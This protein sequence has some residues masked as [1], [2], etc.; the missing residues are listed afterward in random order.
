M[1]KFDFI[2]D[3]FIVNNTYGIVTSTNTISDK[4]IPDE[5]G[6]F[7]QRIFGPIND[8]QCKCG[9][10]KSV[11]YRGEICPKC[12]VEVNTSRVR[13]KRGGR[14][15]LLLP[16]VNTV[17]KGL[18]ASIFDLPVKNFSEYLSENPAVH[19]LE[20]D[21]V[22]KLKIDGKYYYTVFDTD[23][24]NTYDYGTKAM[25][26]ILKYIDIEHLKS[27]YKDLNT[28]EIL[29]YF[30]KS[31]ISLDNLIHY[32]IYVIPPTYR[33]FYYL[34]GSY[35]VKSGINNY[36]ISLIGRNRR[37]INMDNIIEDER[38]KNI[39]IWREFVFIQNIVDGLILGNYKMNGIPVKGIKELMSGKTG[40]IR[41]NMLGKRVRFTGRSVIVA[42]P[43]CKT[44][45]NEG[46]VPYN[47][48]YD[49]YKP[50]ILNRLGNYG[51][52]K[53]E[54]KIKEYRND[55]NL[56]SKIIYEEIDNK[57]YFVLNRQPT[58]H[59]GSIQ[60]LKVRVNKDKS[61]QAILLDP[62]ITEPLNADFDG[63]T[64]QMIFPMTV[65]AVNDVKEKLLVVKNINNFRNNTVQL[66][67]SQEA[68][69][70]LWYLTS[71]PTNKSGYLTSLED[72]DKTVGFNILFNML[73]QFEAE[74]LLENNTLDKKGVY[75][76]MNNILSS[77]YYNDSYLDR[78][79]TVRE[80]ALLGF[81]TISE[82]GF[83]I[84]FSE[85]EPE[86]VE[87]EN[88]TQ[89][90]KNVELAIDK[91]RKENTSLSALLLSKAR[92]NENQVMQ[93]KIAKGAMLDKL[94][95]ITNIVDNSLSK[96]LST[97]EFIDSVQG[98]RK[99]LIDRSLST[100][101]VGYL[102]AKL[103]KANRDVR[104]TS[105]RCDSTDG[106]FL[107]YYR[108]INRV[109]SEDCKVYD[110]F[111]LEAD[112][113]ITKQI[114]NY[115]TNECPD[116]RDLLLKVRSPLTCSDKNGICAHCYGDVSSKAEEVRVDSNIG[117]L[118]SMI[119]S[120]PA[121]QLIMRTFHTSSSYNAKITEVVSE[122][123]QNIKIEDFNLVKVVHINNHI[124]CINNSEINLTFNKKLRKDGDLIKKGD[125][126]FSFSRNEGDISTKYPELK[127]LLELTTPKLEAVIAEDSGIIKYSRIDYQDTEVYNE[128]TG[129]YTPKKVLDLYF[130]LNDKEYKINL[131]IND[132]FVRF[133]DEVVIGQS[134][135]N[136]SKNYCK[137]FNILPYKDFVNTLLNDIESIYSSV[138]TS[139]DSI[140]FEVVLSNMLSLFREVETG[141]IVNKSEIKSGF[142]YERILSSLLKLGTNRSFFQHSSL[143]YMNKAFLRLLTDYN[144]IG[145]T[146]ADKL[147]ISEL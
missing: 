132:V 143:G 75:K 3:D 113:V 29:D 17:F 46:I 87:Y 61:V 86:P 14:I 109:L 7:S 55:T 111:I 71:R 53:Y 72:N 82:V 37:L 20:T 77:D 118:S 145:D 102:T 107:P 144:F 5:D 97:D 9:N 134:L 38:S 95:N 122:Y 96:G 19:L 26:S 116:K 129:M 85:I 49:V 110:D 34:K 54:D 35:V 108:C 8:Y 146:V 88:S 18:V 4:G 131:L 106:I 136:G 69:L 15:E 24:S 11:L 50:L 126:A 112:T 44:E 135:T 114:I 63:D 91:I 120:E 62:L 25:K 89:F 47:I 141:R 31:N 36:Y 42:G 101:E 123:D 83:S 84:R 33:D 98:A 22:T 92:G 16:I 103:V 56:I 147:S 68:V 80:M 39:M 27:F 52:I 79:K 59:P 117:T 139:I 58:L 90:H 127:A 23:T 57:F 93:I 32:N 121:I 67:I 48:I 100:G 138:G 78:V 119:L 130:T 6:I 133:N 70:G 140:H 128:K 66:T 115:I 40:L 125:V 30:I 104:I 43:D 51:I 99:G 137:L 64:T 73:K 1:K 65:E 74:Y 12:G 10:L 21:K 94:G 28:K 105:T 124:Y 81:K 45:N 41:M 142:T 60:G 76:I 2:S 13:K